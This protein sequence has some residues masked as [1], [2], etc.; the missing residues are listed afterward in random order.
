[1]L[2]LNTVVLMFSSVVSVILALGLEQ[3]TPV[4][5]TLAPFLLYNGI[6]LVRYCW[7]GVIWTF[8]GEP[9][10]SYSLAQS[11]EDK[12][13]VLFGKSPNYEKGTAESSV[14][15][16]GAIAGWGIYLFNITATTL[17]ITVTGVALFLLLVKT[18]RKLS[19]LRKEKG[20]DK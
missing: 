17:L 13:K 18:I 15:A 14:L 8:G 4:L 6:A 3:L 1:M 11:L 19:I 5:I 16:L 2:G 20:L 10:W 12:W 7:Y 9:E